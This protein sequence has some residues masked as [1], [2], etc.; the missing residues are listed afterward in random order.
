MRLTMIFV[1]EHCMLP[2]L[3]H[4]IH[5]MGRKTKLSARKNEERSKQQR[6]INKAGRPRTV[7]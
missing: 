1:L 2:T 3:V 7:K 6:G 5:R 4:G